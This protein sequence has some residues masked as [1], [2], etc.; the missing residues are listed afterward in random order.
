MAERKRI[1]DSLKRD[2]SE[3]THNRAMATKAKMEALEKMV[4]VIA[5]Y[6]EVETMLK[7]S[8]IE[9]FDYQQQA[10]EDEEKV[11]ARRTAMAN[12]FVTQLMGQGEQQQAQG[13]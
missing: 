7:M 10:N 11:D 2:F 4:D 9:S 1:L 6:G 5:K 13:Q 12:D 3:I 8:Q